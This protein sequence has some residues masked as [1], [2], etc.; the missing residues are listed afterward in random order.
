MECERGN[1]GGAM[2]NSREWR[3]SGLMF[4]AVLALDLL[5]S[6]FQPHFQ[7]ISIERVNLPRLKP[8]PPRQ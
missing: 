6:L 3:L 4:A 1:G 5:F 8:E 7:I 2:Q